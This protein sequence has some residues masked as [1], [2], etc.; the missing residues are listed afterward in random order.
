[1]DSR[2]VKHFFFGGNGG[3]GWEKTR[4]D[5][6]EKM[7]GFL[8]KLLMFLRKDKGQL[9]QKRMADGRWQFVKTI[10]NTMNKYF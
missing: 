2:A 6:F 8:K 9:F 7:K 4:K 1:M 5:F 3:V 10:E